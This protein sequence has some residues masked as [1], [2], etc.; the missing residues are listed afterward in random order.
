MRPTDQ[1][2]AHAAEYRKLYGTAMWKRLR[3]RQ[4]TNEPLC[5]FC[6]DCGDVVV[7]TVV[8]HIKP[9]RGDECLFFDADNLRSLCKP[10]HDS[11]G[12]REDLGQA[13]VT[14]NADGWLS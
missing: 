11:E 1:R 12:Q 13:I 5:R 2:S 9:H 7:A 14:F 3:E 10:H 4:L 8:D 6:L